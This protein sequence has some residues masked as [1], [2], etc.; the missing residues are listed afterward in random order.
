[1]KIRTIK[2]IINLGILGGVGILAW[3]YGPSV[4]VEANYQEQLK[5]EEQANEMVDPEKGF[6][7]LLYSLSGFETLVEANE[8]FKEFGA[9]PVSG[10]FGLVIPKIFV[11]VAVA[12]N[13]NPG[14]KEVYQRILGETG[15][16]AHAAGSVVPGEPGTTYIFGHS[17]DASFDVTRFNAMFYLLRKLEAGDLIISYYNNIP[18][19]YTVVEKKVV[20]PDDISDIVNV[21]N[22]ERLV[23]QTCWPPGTDWKRLLIIAKP[24]EI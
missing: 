6:D 5:A 14:D 19:R 10:R 7:E 22:E 9:E 20:A 21:A 1:M 3:I 17:T 18:H 13:V 12:E 16:V 15:G 11:N 23:L 8:P 24:E 4:L 2:W